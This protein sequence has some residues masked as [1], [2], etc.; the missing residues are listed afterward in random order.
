MLD[1]TTAVIVQFRRGMKVVSQVH[2]DGESILQTARRA[3]LKI[4]SNCE[5]GMCGTC[6]AQLISGK[7]RMRND[8]ALSIDQLENGFILTCQSIPLTKECEVGLD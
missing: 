6:I 7:V 8:E 2:Y 5:K 3:G 1:T 4:P